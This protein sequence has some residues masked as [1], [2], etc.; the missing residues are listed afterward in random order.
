M[1]SLTLLQLGELFYKSVFM[2]L[3]SYAPHVLGISLRSISCDAYQ[4]SVTDINH[5]CK[6][7]EIMEHDL[8]QVLEDLD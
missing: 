4:A 7:R 1:Y 2:N 6:V 3:S 8:L 5:F